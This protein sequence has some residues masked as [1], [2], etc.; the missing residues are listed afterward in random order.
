LA[1]AV[2]VSVVRPRSAPVPDLELPELATPP[3]GCN[4]V[5]LV[6]GFLDAETGFKRFCFVNTEQINIIIGR[7]DTD[8][9]IEHAAISRAHLRVE[10][11]GQ[12]IT[13]SDL[14][15]RNGTFIG[16]V[17]C[18]PGEVMFLGTD[19]EICLGDVKLTIR[20]VRQE[21]EWA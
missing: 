3:D 13:V 1:T 14:G 6:E 9:A 17:P 18:L 12:S 8:I 2:D 16:D 4:G 19:D 11:D 10:S 21:A 15:S 5:L 7:G 20:V